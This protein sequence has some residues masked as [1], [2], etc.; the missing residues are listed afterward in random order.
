MRKISTKNYII[1]GLVCIL[2]GVLLIC[3]VNMYNNGKEYYDN[4][5]ER[6]NFLKEIK[7]S[8]IKNYFDENTDYAIYLS[9]SEEVNNEEFEN[10]LRKKLIKK[11][12]INDIVYVNTKDL[13]IDL[14]KLIN[15]EYQVNFD[16][17]PNL[18]V[19]SDGEIAD[20]YYI[21]EYAKAEDVVTILEAY[22]D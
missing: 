15:D 16:R 6:M 20:T 4:T 22:Y 5:N 17:L 10:K 9:N 19:V 13:S 8:E 12:Y 1:Y 3:W 11:D 18:I 21:G 14:L 7:E 2:T